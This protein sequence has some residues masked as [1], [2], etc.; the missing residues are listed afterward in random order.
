MATVA[1]IRLEQAA[2]NAANAGKVDADGEEYV[3]LAV[4]GDVGPLTMAARAFTSSSTGDADGTDADADGTD[5]TDA[6]NTDADAGEIAKLQGLLDTSIA[7]LAASKSAA[8]TLRTTLSESNQK[9]FDK[10]AALETDI[11]GSKAIIADTLA[12]YGLPASLATTLNNA[13]VGGESGTAIAM[14]I[15]ETPEYAARFPAMAQRRELNLPAV[16]EADYLNLERNFR[17]IMQAAK[18]PSTFHDAPED[19]DQLIS[20]DVSPQ[21]FQERVTL[22][23]VA[24]DSASTETRRLLNEFYDISEGDLTAYYL[25]PTR[26]ETIFE[27]R[28][29]M[30]SAG[31]AAASRQT[32]G[33]DLTVGT[34]EALQAEN[35]QRRE[36]QQRLGQRVGLTD[37]LLGEEEALTASTIA[38]AEFGL[39]VESATRM[40]RRRE[41]RTTGFTGRSGALT[42]AGGVTSLGEA[43]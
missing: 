9:L 29:R 1:E 19:F 27:D 24:R 5:G 30:E 39:D 18:L 7:D 20:G 14:Q 41:E 2:L 35:V 38:E 17:T 37:Q 25:D 28:R 33:Q 40:R 21:E 10:T 36:I 13:L 3:P 11:K 42:T 22:A 26:A 23:E 4:D 12:L 43:T 8:N 6:D 16:S 32:I 31:L 15:R 34:A